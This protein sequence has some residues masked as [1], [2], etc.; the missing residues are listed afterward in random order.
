MYHKSILFLIHLALAGGLFAQDT[1]YLS[2]K[3]RIACTVTEIAQQSIEYLPWG[4]SRNYHR[5]SKDQVLY[6][7]YAGG[8]TDTFSLIS[9][10]DS[11]R[12]DS[13]IS[14]VAAFETGMTHGYER[15]KPRTESVAG[16]MSWLL[17]YWSWVIP[18]AYSTSKI[19]PRQI[20]DRQFQSS[21]NIYYR[22]GY[23]KGAMRRRRQAVWTS[24]GV[25]GT[26]I[27]SAVVYTA[28]YW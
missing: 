19:K 14:T 12:P 13:F 16:G 11:V 6:I 7:R 23:L 21:T 9:A 10:V 22:E 1:M 2:D 24:Y 5:I 8:K 4:D 15:Y 26:V 20:D 25:T 28:L 3:Q 18:L 17:T 27:V